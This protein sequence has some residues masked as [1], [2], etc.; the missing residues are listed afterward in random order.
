MSAGSVDGDY[1]SARVLPELTQY[2]SGRST[3]PSISARRAWKS[4][5]AILKHANQYG[6]KY[7]FVRDRY[8]EPLLAFA[9]WR[10]AESYDNGNVTLWTKEDVPPAKRID[11]GDIMPSAM[12]GLHVGH[13]AGRSE[14]VRDLRR[15]DAAGGTLRGSGTGGGSRAVPSEDHVLVREVK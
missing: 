6:L 2:G 11:F 4:L 3:T 12:Q 1:N 8:Y 15:P 13:S 10:Q 14:L 9:G 7:I 5:R